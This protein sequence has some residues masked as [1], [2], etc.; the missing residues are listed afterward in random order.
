MKLVLA[1]VDFSEVTSNLV[2]L[3]GNVARG[4][5]SKLVLVHVAMPDADFVD[6]KVRDNVSRDALAG[7]LRQRH[8]K[9]EILEL[10]LRKLGVDATGLMVRST[11]SRGNPVNKIVDEVDRLGPDMVIMGTHG[12]GRLYEML[13]GSVTNAVVRKVRRPVLVVPSPMSGGSKPAGI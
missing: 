1:L 11:S 12:H 4:M 13:V 7:D 3:A 2:T 5:N 6:G 10:E 9:L 8:R